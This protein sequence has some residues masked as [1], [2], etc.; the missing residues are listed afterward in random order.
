MIREIIIDRFEAVDVYL[1][2]TADEQAWD[3]YL[4]PINKSHLVDWRRLINPKCLIVEDNHYQGGSNRDKL[5]NVWKKFKVLGHAKR[6][7]ELSDGP[8]DMVIKMRPD[9]CLTDS[10]VFGQD[11]AIENYVTISKNKV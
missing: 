4:N 10:Q 6:L 5:L 3:N 8:Y 9:L 1:H 2:V 7:N 11:V